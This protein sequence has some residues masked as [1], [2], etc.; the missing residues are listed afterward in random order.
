LPV[1][2]YKRPKGLAIAEIDW[3]RLQRTDAVIETQTLPLWIKAPLFRDVGTGDDLAPRNSP[4]A[5]AK[6]NRRQ[7]DC[8]NRGGV[9][10]QSGKDGSFDMRAGRIANRQAGNRTGCQRLNALAKRNKCVI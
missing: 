6:V 2:K 4:Y 10:G 5:T 3:T 7:W 1:S 8:P 9:L